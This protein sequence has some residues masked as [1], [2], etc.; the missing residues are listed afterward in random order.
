MLGLGALLVLAIPFVDGWVLDRVVDR[1]A[2]AG[3]V[4]D[5]EASD[6]LEEYR[7]QTTRIVTRMF[8]LLDDHP[9]VMRFFHG[10]SLSVD[11][12]RLARAHDAY[13]QFSERFLRNGVDKGFLRADLDTEITS[14]ALVGII[15]EGTRRALHAPQPEDVRRRWVQAGVALMFDGVAKR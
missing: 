3:L 15:F 11:P 10:Q 7:E 9:A 8:D 1:I 12:D 5:P 13:A 2:Q 4:E 14:Q 6:T